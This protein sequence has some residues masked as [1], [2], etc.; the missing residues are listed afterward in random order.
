MQSTPA[1]RRFK[2]GAEKAETNQDIGLSRGGRNTKIHAVVDA[3]GNPVKL[4]LTP[5]NVND[6]T[7]AIDVLDGVTLSGSIVMGDKAYG[8]AGIR[9][10]IEANGGTYCIPPKDNAK[11]PWDCDFYQY[12]ERH[13]VE[14]F[15]NKIKQFRRVNNVFF[16][17]APEKTRV[18]QS[19]PRGVKEN[20]L[21][22]TADG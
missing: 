4:H 12:K 13:L 7:V 21:H 17:S 16:D 1:R 10:F 19:F 18:S 20:V 3:L 15:F 22:E 9:E 11:Q 6:C 8:T 2:K 14:C 5:G